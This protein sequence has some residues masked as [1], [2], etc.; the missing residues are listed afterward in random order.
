MA[1]QLN[2]YLLGVNGFT[3]ALYWAY[4][5]TGT[6][7]APVPYIKIYPST[8]SYPT[9]R[10]DNAGSL[11]AGHVLQYTSLSFSISGGA[12]ALTGGTVTATC[13]AA[14]TLSW[15]AIY[16]SNYV[17]QCI[18]TDSVALAGTGSVIGV[19]NL[20]PALSEIVTVS[21]NLKFF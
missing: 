14:E 12:I 1:L 11:P 20:T 21:F 13:S 7:T 5:F 2:P 10:V 3:K 8:V 9:S 4:I 6:G 17:N 16:A 15:A 18:I 19:S